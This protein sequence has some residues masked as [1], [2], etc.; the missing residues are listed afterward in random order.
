MSRLA[1][2]YLTWERGV[3]LV[4]A[5]SMAFAAVK[6]SAQVSV[7]LEVHAHLVVAYLVVLALGELGRVR[8][9]SG[10]ETTPVATASVIALA[11]TALLN[12]EAPFATST[13][14]VVLVAACGSGIGLL[15]RWAAGRE[16]RLYLAMAR[17]LAAFVVAALA[18]AVEFGGTSLWELQVDPTRSTPFLAVAMLAIA[19]VGVFLELILGSLVR[20]QRHHA[21]WDTV[22]RDDLREA[23][24]LNVAL[25]ASGPLVALLSPTLGLAAL[26]LALFPM[27]LTYVAVDRYVANQLTYRQM[28][29]TLS[30]LTEAGGYTPRAHAE[31]VAVLAVAMAR[32]L[33]LLQREV[34]EVEYAALL[35]DLG[36]IA[37]REPI[38]GGA[39]VLAAPSDQRRIAADGARIVRHAGVLDR[40]ADLIEVQATPYREVRELGEDVP[41]ASRI[42][43]V[44]NAFDDLTEGRR[45]ADTE[46]RA[47]ER[48]NLGLGYEYDPAIV[49]ALATVLA[50]PV[51][52]RAPAEGSGGLVR[53]AEV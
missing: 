4:G 22:L 34:S 17:L 51:G 10:R 37:L 31:R 44:A 28:I 43:K 38:P 46:S 2:P 47:M 33:G 20:A 52:Q 30:R 45:G 32:T 27:A 12:G 23:P 25:I 6:A 50:S 16:V 49:E 11:F 15:V 5:A 9:P 18:R 13:S 53:P 36:Q 48:I 19:A 35:H 39:T 3:L 24:A 7:L 42:I 40:V 41:L 26:P 14:M 29:A 8:L 1:G 21:P